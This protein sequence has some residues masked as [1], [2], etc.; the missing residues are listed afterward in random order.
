MEEEVPSANA[1]WQE[2]MDATRVT[3]EEYSP[4]DGFVYNLTNLSTETAALESVRAQYMTPLLCGVTQDLEAD[5]A[6]VQAQ[7][8]KAGIDNYIAEMQA[9]LT[10]FKETKAAE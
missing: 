9:Q 4:L 6:N 3:P 2:Q 8:D 7:L 10:A 1:Y 5:F